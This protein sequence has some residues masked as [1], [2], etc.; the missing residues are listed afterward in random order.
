MEHPIIS[1]AV[2]KSNIV[3][4][5]LASGEIFAVDM[6]NSQSAAIGSHDVPICKLFWVNEYDL[7]MSMGYDQKIKFWNMQNSG[8][9]LAK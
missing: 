9:F 6:T 5:G 8:N 1:L 4:A 2:G 7:L 3:F